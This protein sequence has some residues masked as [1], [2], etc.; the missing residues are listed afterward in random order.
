MVDST[1]SSTKRAAQVSCA[2]MFVLSC[3][4]AEPPG[5]LS[6]AAPTPSPP[7]RVVPVEG[8]RA[9]RIAEPPTPGFVL[10]TIDET[11]IVPADGSTRVRGPGLWVQDDR[12]Q[13]PKLGHTIVLTDT[14]V[15]ELELP[16]CEC[17]IGPDACERGSVRTQTLDAS[18][19]TLSGDRGCACVRAAEG[20]GFPPFVDEDGHRYAACESGSEQRFAALVGG[21]LNVH[22]W[23]WNGACFNSLSIYDA[24]SW[25]VPLVDDPPEI[26][27]STMGRATCWDYGPAFVAPVWPPGVGAEARLDSCD[28]YYE[29]EV[30]MLRRGNLWSVRDDISGVHGTRQLRHRPARPDSCPTVNDP[31]GDPAPF[32]ERAGLRQRRREYWVATDGSVSLTAVGDRYSLWSFD[33]ESPIEF[34]LAGIDATGDLLGVRYHADTRPLQ[35]FIEGPPVPELSDAEVEV[36]SD[37]CR[38]RHRRYAS[39]HVG[40]DGKPRTATAWGNDCFERLRI[41]HWHSA[42]ASCLEG[43]AVAEDPRT[44]GA[45]LYNLGR[46]AEAQGA[47]AQAITRYRDSLAARPGSRA[48]MRRLARLT[49]D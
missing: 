28:A 40:W 4:A 36:S 16:S 41:R 26:D 37:E 1:N 22:G 9:P 13:P 14:I 24:D 20:A 25:R 23:D 12:Q 33:E 11:I 8:E 34:Q 21:A 27:P 38:A 35:R 31:C 30:F 39:R 43:L 45:L 48:A 2:L 29:S 7:V 19:G 46:I 47:T 32:E 15:N 18:T 3:T 10:Y 6:F 49:R 42:E 17:V 44:R 5:S